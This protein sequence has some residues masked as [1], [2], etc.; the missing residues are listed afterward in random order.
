MK[1]PFVTV[2]WLVVLNAGILQACSSTPTK[3]SMS[4]D[5][6]TLASVDFLQGSRALANRLGEV[7]LH[8]PISTYDKAGEKQKDYAVVATYTAASGRTC[9][10]IRVSGKSGDDDMDVI[11]RSAEKHWFWPPNVI[12]E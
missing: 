4:E 2:A 10:Q 11:C 6:A 3:P 9:R 1:K 5:S 12:S 7:A 8:E